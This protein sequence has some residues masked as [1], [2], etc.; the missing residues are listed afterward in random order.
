MAKLSLLQSMNC[1]VNILIDVCKLF[2]PKMKKRAYKGGIINVT[3]GFGVIPI[4]YT[5]LFSVSNC[6]ADV[7]SRSLSE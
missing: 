7:F 2:V 6:Y 5:G 1:N 4:P 3:S